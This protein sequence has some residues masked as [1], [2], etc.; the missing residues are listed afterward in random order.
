MLVSMNPDQYFSLGQYLIANKAYALSVTVITQFKFPEGVQPE[1]V[2]VNTKVA[3]SRIP[4]EN[5]I[6]LL[7]NRWQSF[8]ELRLRL[9]DKD[10]DMQHI[11][12]WV[13]ACARLHKLLSRCYGEVSRG[14]ESPSARAKSQET[15]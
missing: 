12:T 10:G 6:S 1:N 4:V 9:L 14:S 5:T 11:N 13:V 7:K 3:G 8:R 2:A 15:S